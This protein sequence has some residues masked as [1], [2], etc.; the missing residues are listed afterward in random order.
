MPP[1]RG[2]AYIATGK[3]HSG[4]VLEKKVITLLATCSNQVGRTSSQE[5]CRKDLLPTVDGGL[6]TQIDL[7]NMLS[8]APL[9]DCKLLCGLILKYFKNAYYLIDTAL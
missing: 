1:K 8:K 5:H 7:S 4:E 3:K 6:L 9:N 2:Q